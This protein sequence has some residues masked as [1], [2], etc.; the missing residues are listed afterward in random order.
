MIH[1]YALIGLPYRLGANPAEH[2][3]ADCLTLA[4]TVLAWHGIDTPKPQRSWYRRLRRGDIA[5]FKEE[6]SRWGSVTDSP[7]LGTV[8]ICQS[9]L[10]LGMA[11]YFDSGWLHFDESVV[12]WSPCGVLPV[13]AYYCHTN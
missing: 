11:S 3:A 1:P 8:A 4:R 2:G 6:L 13:V 5:V 12:R 9:S 7:T 10:G